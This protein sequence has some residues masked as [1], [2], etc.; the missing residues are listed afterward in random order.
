M[1]IRSRETQLL[2]YYS[3][4]NRNDEAFNLL[5]QWRRE[6]ASKESR[7][8]YI[9]ASNRILDMLSAFLPQSLDELKQI[10]GFGDNRT[11]TYG[12]AI[13]TLLKDFPRETAFP[14]HWVAEMVNMQQFELWLG[15][16]KRVR[17]QTEEAKLAGKRKLL[18][19]IAEGEDLSAIE[20]KLSMKRRD[21]LL[22]VEEL[23]KEGYDVDAF[24]DV[25]LGAVDQEEQLQV[26]QLFKQLGDR[27]LKPVLFKLYDEQQLK[28]KDVNKTYEWMRLLRLKHR[29]QTVS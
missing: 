11:R 18:E 29:K 13:I 22:A 21:I 5:R 28:E 3:E 17:Q 25:E 10:P 19:A 4:L 8:V 26:E 23:A 6:E 7:P 24:I 2:Y 9:V 1:S 20:I 27:Y 15:E 14:L 12:E 16:Q